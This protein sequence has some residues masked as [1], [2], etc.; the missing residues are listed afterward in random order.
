[1]N[2]DYNFNIKRNRPEEVYEKVTDYFKNDVL[3]QYASSKSMARI[4]QKI[5]KR[6]L[7][8]LNLKSGKSLILDAGC[9]PGFAAFYL[10]EMGYKIVALDIITEFL[11]YYEI[12]HL[13]PINSDMCSPPFRPNIFDAIIS[14][15]AL[16]WIFR[17]INN[18]L[19]L[20]MTK[21]LFKAFFQIL[22]PNRKALMQFYPKNKE[23]VKEIGKIITIYTDFKGE[24]IIDNPNNEKKRK[25]FLLLE[26]KF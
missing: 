23:T 5:T 3:N 24:F 6:A 4:Q 12:N 8:L 7:E 15:S 11:T 20:S 14:I 19:M 2:K 9:G 1:M 16:Q 22:R 25:I 13:N 26:K 21:S 10:K 17:D 18:N